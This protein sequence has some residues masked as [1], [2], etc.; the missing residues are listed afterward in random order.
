MCPCI[1]NVQEN[2]CYQVFWA[3]KGPCST[4]Q[5]LPVK[6]QSQSHKHSGII[7]QHRTVNCTLLYQGVAKPRKFLTYVSR[8]YVSDTYWIHHTVNTNPTAL[9]RK[10]TED[11]RCESFCILPWCMNSGQGWTSLLILQLWHNSPST[12]VCLLTAAAEF[13]AGTLPQSD[14]DNNLITKILSCWD[15]KVCYPLKYFMSTG[16]EPSALQVSPFFPG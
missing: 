10:V 7:L 16:E 15:F 6:G 4:A 11:S 5:L 3:S 12:A 8:W 14:S 13:I 2:A 9:D 1:S